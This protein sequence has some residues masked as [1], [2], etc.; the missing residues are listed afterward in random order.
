MHGVRPARPDDRS[1]VAR[2][3]AAAFAADPAW[4]FLL[5]A[6]YDRLAP[7]FAGTIFDSRVGTG[8]VWV[9]ADL[10]SVAMWEPP[11]RDAVAPTTP[12]PRW[13]AY[14]AVAG[15]VV[16]RR[17]VDYESAVDAARPNS[18]YWYLGVLATDPSHQRAGGA[19]A[20]L[21]PVLEQAD[22]AGLACCLETSTEA[23]RAFYVR[24]G[25]TEVTTVDIPDGP[26]TWWLRRPP[27]ERR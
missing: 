19:S 13:D 11:R 21:G 20:V 22:A 7:L 9:S 25:F 23:N 1:A 10:T 17:L 16:W 14:R 26:P 8:H 12:G 2:S 27:P 3:V 5:G 18:A 6:D 24:R 15:E 4:N